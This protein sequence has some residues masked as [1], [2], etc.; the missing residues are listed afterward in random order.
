MLKTVKRTTTLVLML[1]IILSLI[2]LPVGAQHVSEL[3]ATEVNVAQNIAPQ[4]VSQTRSTITFTCGH[5]QFGTFGSVLEV[6]DYKV[7]L[8]KNKGVA[9]CSTG[10]ISSM[11][12]LDPDS[13]VIGSINTVSST[14]SSRYGVLT[15]PNKSGYYTIRVTGAMGSYTLNCLTGVGTTS[16]TN[17]DYYRTGA[18]MYAAMYWNNSNTYYP[19]F[20]A[21][22]TNFVS[23][24]VHSA[25]MPMITATSHD[26]ANDSHWYLSSASNYSPSWTGADFFMRH[27]T[28][29]RL[30]S[31]NG[32]AYSVKIY[33]RDYILN[34]WNTFVSNVG[35]GDIIQYADGGDSTVYHSAVI[36]SVNQSTGYV[37]FY[38][39]SSY[40][41]SGSLNTYITDEISNNEW[42]IIIRISSN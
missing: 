18:S 13:V 28:K 1:S 35:I 36:G 41:N 25:Y 42:I 12:V 6:R 29:V 4:G 37:G 3:S 40:M 24:A 31:Y 39:H 34:N 26:D 9:F 23:Q 15:L 17:T 22:C 27:W 21:D 10:T 32:R 38:S 5:E 16:N 33:T 30:S 20:G 7:Y 2:S 19:V 8:Q 11:Q 14:S